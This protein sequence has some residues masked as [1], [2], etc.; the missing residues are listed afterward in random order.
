MISRLSSLPV[1]SPA[2]V[3]FP[4]FPFVVGTTFGSTGFA[5]DGAIGVKARRSEAA[6]DEVRAL[7][8]AAGTR[9][10]SGSAFVSGSVFG[11]GSAFVSGSAFGSGVS[12]EA[13]LFST[14]FSVEDAT[15][16]LLLLLSFFPIQ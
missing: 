5:F 6:A 16:L 2:D 12:T 8:A 3:F 1:P 9:D 14:A 7:A 13:A 4:A 11:S 10:G 15:L